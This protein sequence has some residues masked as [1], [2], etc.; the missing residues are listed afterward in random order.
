MGS[1]F[2][3]TSPT[4][5]MRSTNPMNLSTSILGATRRSPIVNIQ[6]LLSHCSRF[7]FAVLRIPRSVV[8]VVAD[9]DVI[10]CS[11]VLRSSEVRP[12]SAASIIRFSTGAEPVVDCGAGDG[13]DTKDKGG[14]GDGVRE[15]TEDEELA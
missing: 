15:L 6:R 12:H 2:E 1:A 14:W 9:E 10:C 8:S 11:I 4:A 13:A 5:L 3:A 7:A